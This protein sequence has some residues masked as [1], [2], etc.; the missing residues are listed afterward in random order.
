MRRWDESKVPAH[1]GIV[2]PVNG[3]ERRVPEPC[4]IDLASIIIVDVLEALKESMHAAPSWSA[5]GFTRIEKTTKAHVV[6]THC[7]AN[8][9]H[10]RRV[11]EPPP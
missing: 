7:L 11:L 8:A 6:V 10:A 9:N 4:P 5:C 3:D 1:N 2:N